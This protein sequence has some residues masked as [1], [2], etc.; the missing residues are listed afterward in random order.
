MRDVIKVTQLNIQRARCVVF[1]ISSDS[2]L[3]NISWKIRLSY[4][5]VVSTLL[6]IILYW[7]RVVN[8][9]LHGELKL[10]SQYSVISN[11]S[12]PPDVYK[13]WLV[14]IIIFVVEII[15]RCRRY[16]RLLETEQRTWW[17]GSDILSGCYT[18]T[19]PSGNHYSR[20]EIGRGSTGLHLCYW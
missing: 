2:L 7:I 11:H 19:T 17:D 16:S 15:S 6:N 3:C 14:L 4:C 13:C 18:P 8:L 20:D 5:C 12:V 10:L 9:S 1:V